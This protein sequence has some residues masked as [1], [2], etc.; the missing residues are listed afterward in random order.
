MQKMPTVF[1]TCYNKYILYT[2]LYQGF[3]RIEYHRL[4]IYRQ[5]VLVRYFGGWPKP[6]SQP[7]SQN[8]SFHTVNKSILRYKCF[9]D[10]RDF[11]VQSGSMKILITGG[12]GFIGSNFVHYV[13]DRHSDEGGGLDK[14]AYAGRK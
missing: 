8:H 13:L 5:Q 9:Y 7:T 11:K 1:W 6:C 14:L 4:V 2:S 10:R 3:Q 12:A